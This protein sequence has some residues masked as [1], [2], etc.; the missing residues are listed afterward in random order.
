[1]MRERQTGRVDHWLAHALA[2]GVA[3]LRRFA[4]GLRAD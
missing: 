1:M 4:I 2:S 3:P